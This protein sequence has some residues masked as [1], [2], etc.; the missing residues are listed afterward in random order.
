MIDSA[1]VTCHLV[2]DT[3]TPGVEEAP[4]QVHATVR[5]THPD[6][7]S[8]ETGR[9]RESARPDQGVRGPGPDQG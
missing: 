5:A 2:G 3:L 8:L 6:T 1:L 4:W 9:L 7:P